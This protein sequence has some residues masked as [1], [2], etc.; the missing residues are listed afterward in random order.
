MRILLF[1]F[2]IIGFSAPTFSQNVLV[3]KNSKTGKTRILKPKA[4]LHFKTIH[5]SSFV[6]ARILQIKDS[7]IVLYIPEFDDAMPMMDILYTELKEIQKPTGFHAFSRGIAAGLLPIG[8]FLFLDGA[9]TWPRDSDPYYKNQ[10]KKL[11]FIGLGIAALGTL[12]YLIKPKYY[13]LKG[14]WEIS[15]VKMKK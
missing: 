7:S 2:L 11:T 6:K 5:D 15:V 1:L 13:N 4:H 10:S 12:P 14:E 8:S 9:L 3:L